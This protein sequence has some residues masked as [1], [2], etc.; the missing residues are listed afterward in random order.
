MTKRLL[1]MLAAGSLVTP[2]ALGAQQIAGEYQVEVRGTTHYLDRAPATRQLRDNTALYVQQDGDVIEIEFRSFASAMSTTTFRGRVGNDRFVALWTSSGRPAEALLITGEVDGRRLRGRL[3]YPR[4]KPDAAVP[5][6]TEVE[7]SAVR[8]ERRGQARPDRKPGR[9]TPGERLARP[10]VVLRP[11]TGGEA[12]SNETPFEV[13]IAAMTDPEAPLAGHRIDFIARATPL[14][15][16]ESVERTELW[17]NGLVQG[18]SD[19]NLLE[20]EAGPFRAGRLDYDI[21]A[22]ADDGRRSELIRRSVNVTAAGNTTI[23][24]RL[25]GSRGKISDVQLVRSDGRTV[26]K[27]SV[28]RSGRY[29]FRRIP[30][31]K[32]VIFVN[33][34]K[35]EARVSPTSNLEIRVDGRSAYTRNFEIR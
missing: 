6:W 1:S 16:G 23:L 34:A 22:V 12:A 8:P 2:T 7:F 4:A 15:S 35:T 5:G 14:R 31:G 18:S 25:T 33:D 11:A 9:L 32:Y 10:G 17:I 30:A 21:V 3:L 13:D 20:V 28:S 24:G 19:G 27:S 26:A 29:R